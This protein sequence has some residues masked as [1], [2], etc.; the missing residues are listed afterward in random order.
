MRASISDARRPPRA[1]GGKKAS[2]VRRGARWMRHGA[3]QGDPAALQRNTRAVSRYALV[4][5]FPRALFDAGFD[6]RCG[7]RCRQSIAPALKVA[8]IRRSRTHSAAL[9]PNRRTA[10][11]PLDEANVGTV[12]AIDRGHQH[13]RLSHCHHPRQICRLRSRRTAATAPHHCR[14]SSA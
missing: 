1:G 6:V 12:G 2:L 5:P 10:P 9:K 13:Q 11:P 8:R 4:A 14:I 3:P 7:L